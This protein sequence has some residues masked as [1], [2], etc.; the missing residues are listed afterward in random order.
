[1]DLI[2]L[3]LIPPPALPSTARRHPLPAAAPRAG[4]V[5]HDGGVFALAVAAFAGLL[6]L[7]RPG[8]RRGLFDWIPPTA[9]ETAGGTIGGSHS[10]AF[11][12]D[13]SRR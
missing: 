12:L 8:V 10:V 5:R 1:M 7:H 6:G 3:I 2:R 13:P 4:G 11:R 9:L